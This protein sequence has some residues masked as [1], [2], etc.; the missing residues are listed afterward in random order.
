MTT[1]IILFCDAETMLRLG[2]T[3]NGQPSGIF[4]IYLPSILNPL[5]KNVINEIFSERDHER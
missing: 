1:I 5:I 3:A 4:C 2:V